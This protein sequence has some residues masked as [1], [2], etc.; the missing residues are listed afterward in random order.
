MQ[1]ASRVASVSATQ[2]QT[3]SCDVL[4]PGGEGRRVRLLDEERAGPDQDVGADHVLDRVEDARMADQ[5]VEPGGMR[6][7]VGA[8]FH[9]RIRHRAAEVGFQ[10]GEAVEA[11]R[12]FI[13]GQ[14][15]DAEEEAVVA[16][17]GELFGGDG[18][19]GS[20]CQ[21]SIGGAAQPPPPISSITAPRETGW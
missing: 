13:G 12:D 15:G 21:S 7:G 5:R 16:V 14:G 9:V 6:V 10:P 8:P 3:C 20:S 4:V 18:F 11:G 17:G 2:A 1:P 19:H